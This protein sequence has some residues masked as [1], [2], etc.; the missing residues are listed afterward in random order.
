ME[1]MKKTYIV[2]IIA[3]VLIFI[4]GIVLFV[5]SIRSNRAGAEETPAPTSTPAPTATPDPNDIANDIAQNTDA[6]IKAEPGEFVVIEDP[7]KPTLCGKLADAITE[8]EKYVASL[9]TEETAV[10]GLTTFLGNQVYAIPLSALDQIPEGADGDTLYVQLYGERPNTVDWDGFIFDYWTW[11]RQEHTGTRIYVF[12]Y[13][14][15][16]DKAQLAWD[17]GQKIL[18][19][20][21]DGP[22]DGIVLNGRLLDSVFTTIV[23]GELYIPLAPVAE[24][25]DAGRF[26]NNQHNFQLT[27]P[28]EQTDYR[29]SLLVPYNP[30]LRPGD[31]HTSEY[32][33]T[34]GNTDPN[35]G[36]LWEDKFRMGDGDAC[37]VPAKELTRYTGWKISYNGRV[38]SI[39]TDARDVSDLFVLDTQGNRSA[40]SQL[41]SSNRVTKYTDPEDIVAI[42]PDETYNEIYGTPETA[43]DAET[44]TDSQTS[45]ALL[46]TPDNS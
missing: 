14:T 6:D 44:D 23:D 22:V 25:F 26:Y 37:Y 31:E 21:D 27:I 17:K 9:C 32:Y 38:T 18:N 35:C 40:H 33:F 42:M 29:L 15:D 11:T 2:A 28:I 30:Y 39:V 24:A 10:P 20:E 46:V 36:E 34:A 43:S 5:L 45:E 41:L 1:K 4:V 8:D 19:G 3:T 12:N 13:Q 7:T 16:I